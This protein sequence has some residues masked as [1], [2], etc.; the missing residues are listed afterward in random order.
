[1]GPNPTKSRKVPHSPPTTET[2]RLAFKVL[3]NASDA[4]PARLQASSQQTY[5]AQN[6]DLQISYEQRLALVT[7]DHERQLEHVHRENEIAVNKLMKRLRDAEREVLASRL[8]LKESWGVV[9]GRVRGLAEYL[10]ESG[11]KQIRG[12]GGKQKRKQKQKQSEGDAPDSNG[13][14]LDM[15]LPM[16]GMTNLTMSADESVGKRESEDEDD[17]GESV[18]IGRSSGV[19]LSRGASVDD[20]FHQVELAFGG[21]KLVTGYDSTVASDDVGECL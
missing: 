2:P 13:N 1:M 10:S 16:R 21:V 6:D 7:A 9:G 3:E 17:E 12:K 8:L 14:G 5:C 11:A 18:T 20:E 15:G 19:P 4:D